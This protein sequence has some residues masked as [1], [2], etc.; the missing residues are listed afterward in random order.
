MNGADNGGLFFLDTNIFIYSFFDEEPGK[1]AIANSWIEKAI[2]TRRGII[3]AQVIQECLNIVM[4]KIPQPL[5][6]DDARNYLRVTLFPL[7]KHF[8]SLG[9]YERSLDIQQITGYSLYDSLI[10]TAAIESGC[11]TLLTED[12]QHGRAIQGVTIRNP[13]LA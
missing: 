3:S 10:L 1:R 5:R 7:W 8:P 13:F 12:L 11:R 6:L 9:F 4:R 2:D